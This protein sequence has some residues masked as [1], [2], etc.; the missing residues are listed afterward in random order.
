MMTERR[1]VSFIGAITLMFTL[2]I[3][4]DFFIH[5]IES[6]QLFMVCVYILIALASENYRGVLR[7]VER[8]WMINGNGD[9]DRDKFLLIKSFLEINVS[10]WDKYWRLY[11]DIVN[12][13]KKSIL[14]MYLLKIPKGSIDLKQFLWIF[15]YIIYCVFIPDPIMSQGL[16]FLIDFLSLGFF[17][18]TGSKVIGLGAFMGNIFE[19]VKIGDEDHIKQSLQLIES[20]IIYGSRHFGYLKTRIKLKEVK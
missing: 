13:K 19:A 5:N 11:Q 6:R 18:F 14:K 17:L 12:K 15:G 20:Q 10:R 4:Q 1:G 7:L 3:F 9:K 8:L 16:N 2:I